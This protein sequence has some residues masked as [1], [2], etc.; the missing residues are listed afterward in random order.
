MK[1]RLINCIAQHKHDEFDWHNIDRVHYRSS[2]TSAISKW[3]FS[4][5]KKDIIPTDEKCREDFK[6]RIARKKAKKHNC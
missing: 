6:E 2:N 3:K 5:Y 4:R 1:K